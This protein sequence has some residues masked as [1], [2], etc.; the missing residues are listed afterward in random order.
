MF[1]EFLFDLYYKLLAKLL[2]IAIVDIYDYI[3]VVSKTIFVLH[4]TPHHKYESL[5]MLVCCISGSCTDAEMPRIFHHI[6]IATYGLGAQLSGTLHKCTALHT[7]NVYGFFFLTREHRWFFFMFV[8]IYCRILIWLYILNM[9][10]VGGSRKSFFCK[11]PTPQ[12]DR[13]PTSPLTTIG[14]HVKAFLPNAPPRTHELY[15]SYEIRFTEIDYKQ[16]HRLVGAEEQLFCL[17]QA[18]SKWLRADL[19][20]AI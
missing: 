4:K 8:F 19:C 3:L 13:R 18:L 16:I 2:I 1:P 6:Y 5:Y 10:S 7:P 20:D 9:V 17:V 14:A 15:L 12:L 11:F